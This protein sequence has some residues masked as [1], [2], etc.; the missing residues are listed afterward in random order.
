MRRFGD[1]GGGGGGGG[2]SRCGDRRR[3]SGGGWVGVATMHGS[4]DGSVSR[5]VGLDRTP[6]SARGSNSIGAAVIHG[7]VVLFS[8]DCA[9]IRG[10]VVH[11]RR[12]SRR[13]RGRGGVGDGVACHDRSINRCVDRAS[14]AGSNGRT[15]IGG[16]VGCGTRWMWS[17][18]VVRGMD[19]V[20]K[21]GRGN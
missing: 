17:G 21:R 8:S 11:D 12:R 6:R 9:S 13:R 16:G 18:G 1:S 3:R 7:S 20:R 15:H 5:C 4:G 14:T 19:R 2:S 10:F